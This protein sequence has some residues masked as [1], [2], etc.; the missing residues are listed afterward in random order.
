MSSLHLEHTCP[1]PHPDI[2]PCSPSTGVPYADLQVL[3]V[4]GMG[5]LLFI[6]HARFNQQEVKCRLYG[7][8]AVE[9]VTLNGVLQPCLTE[10]G[11]QQCRLY[12]QCAVEKVMLHV[13]VHVHASVCVCCKC[14]CVCVCACL[15]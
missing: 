6:A 1:G 9:K 5:C 10:V 8:C 3:C 14:A 4:S 11:V 2:C 12:G 7:Q 15:E 13:R